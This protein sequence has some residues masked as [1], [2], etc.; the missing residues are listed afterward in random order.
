MN[1]Q[2]SIVEEPSGLHR[3]PLEVNKS[4]K[5]TAS[6]RLYTRVIIFDLILLNI[7]LFLI[8]GF[9]MSMQIANSLEL[10]V[11]VTFGFLVNILWVLVGSFTDTYRLFNRIKLDLKIRNLFT[12]LLVYF[13]ILSAFYYPLFFESFQVHFVVPAFLT[14]GL[15]SILFHF[16]VRNYTKLNSSIDFAVIGGKRA[17]LD[18]LNRALSVA[19]GG[20]NKCIGRFGKTNYKDIVSLGDYSRIRQFIMTTD[21]DKL[22]Y[23]DSNLKKD[24]LKNIIQLCRNRFID[25]EIVPRDAMLFER[26]IEVEQVEHLPIFSRRAEPLNRLRNRTLK[27]CFDVVLSGI[28]MVL[29]F[30]WL[31]PLVAALIK[32]ESRGPVFF[33]QKRTGYWN[34]PFDL[35][36]FRTMR[37]NDA[38]DSKQAVMGDSRVTKFG[39]FLR[40]SNIDELP[41]LLNVFLGHMSLVGPR[42]HMIKHTEDYS[43]L[44]ESFMIRHEVRPGITGWAQVSGWRGPTSEVYM[45]AKRLEFD[46]HYIENWN[47]WFDCKCILLTLVNM[48]KGEKN[49]F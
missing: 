24:Q 15:L 42:P 22:I 34:K 31:I 29:I 32:I 28:G 45:M 13:G 48:I 35:I 37:V 5:R 18:Y 2:L 12:G 25:F 38:A 36:K 3:K 1:P 11:A 40:K 30:P 21:F 39:A 16:W 17:N 8:I 7:C 9:Q 23:I 43:K 27:R 47:F 49:A 26:G 20:N 46:V 10:G 4:E 41:Q 44:L 6:E 33:I 14:F 19:Y